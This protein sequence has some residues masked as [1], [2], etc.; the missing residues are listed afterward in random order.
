MHYIR[1]R[2]HADVN[3]EPSTVAERLWAQVGEPTATGCREWTGY[4]DDRG[5][6]KMSVDNHPQWVHIVA[7]EVT[8]GP[9]PDGL[10]VCHHCDNPPCCEPTHLFVGTHAENMADAAQKGRMR[11]WKA[12]VTVCPQG[13]LYDEA[14]TGWGRNA[15]GNR[16]RRCRRCHRDRERDRR[17][18]A[19]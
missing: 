9:V 3:W 14:N 12:K 13:H 8:N 19:R 16:S 17:K 5:Y 1:W 18:V 6:A 7:W 10:E 4:R 15:S 11:P 2:N